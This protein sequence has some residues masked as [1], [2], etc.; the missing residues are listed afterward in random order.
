M[1]ALIDGAVPACVCQD[2]GVTFAQVWHRFNGWQ[3]SKVCYSCRSQR[4]VQRE[5]ER[6]AKN[7]ATD[8][9]V[10]RN[11]RRAGRIM[12]IAMK[13]SDSLEP[14]APVGQASPRL[15]ACG[16]VALYYLRGKRFCRKHRP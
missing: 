5:R 15:C 6:R 9:E 13:R 1:E 2:C 3:P 16:R 7:K 10:L 12:G 11:I 4:N 14:V 8:V